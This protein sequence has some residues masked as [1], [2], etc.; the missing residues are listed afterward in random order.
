MKLKTKDLI[1]IVA[2]IF[3]VSVLVI[4]LSHSFLE[5]YGFN[6]NF[7]ISRYIGLEHWSAFFFFFCNLLNGCLLAQIF[8]SLGKKW[9]MNLLWK[10]AVF[11]VLLGLIVLSACPV[12]LF[13][14]TWGDFG[15]VSVLHRTFASV[16]FVSSLVVTALTLPK[17]KDKKFI[18]SGLAFIIYGVIF[19]ICFKLEVEWFMNIFLPLEALFLGWFVFLIGFLEKLSREKKSQVAEE[20]N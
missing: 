5:G 2:G 20:K 7:S 14:E 6:L 3:V 13:D 19:V 15:T 9:K 12:G 4:V 1:K 18:L 16:M 17:V 8:L 11:A 10:I